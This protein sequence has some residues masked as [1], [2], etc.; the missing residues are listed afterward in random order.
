[1]IQLGSMKYRW[2]AFNETQAKWYRL[3]RLDHKPMPGI[4]VLVQPDLNKEKW[5]WSVRKGA[6]NRSPRIVWG[7]ELSLEDAKHR[8]VE[9]FSD[10]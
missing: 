3:V 2:E 4:E 10:L 1:M 7:K 8:A 6:K 5:F 9:A